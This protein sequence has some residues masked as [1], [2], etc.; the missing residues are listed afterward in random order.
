MAHRIVKK[1]NFG[2]N[3]HLIR[4]LSWTNA[5]ILCHRN[6][7]ELLGVIKVKYVSHHRDLL[8]GSYKCPA[9][10]EKFD[11]SSEPP[12]EFRRNTDFWVPTKTCRIWISVDRAKESLFLGVFSFD[13]DDQPDLEII[14]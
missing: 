5:T 6:F 8:N 4:T 7:L 13:T 12:A 14:D 1:I 3:Q 10:V 9:E 2:V 11:S